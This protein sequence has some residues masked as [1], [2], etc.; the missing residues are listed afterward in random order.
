VW[1]D[2]QSIKTRSKARGRVETLCGDGSLHTA[3]Q[4]ENWGQRKKNKNV[5]KIEAAEMT[6]L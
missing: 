6:K 4:S 5:T 2:E 1:D 3:T